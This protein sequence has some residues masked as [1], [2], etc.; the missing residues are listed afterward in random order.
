MA[1]ILIGRFRAY[2]TIKSVA[3]PTD[4]G[5]NSATFRPIPAP[6]NPA[7]VV[8]PQFFIAARPGP[9]TV[10]FHLSTNSNAGLRPRRHA[11]PQDTISCEF[12]SLE[13]G[14]VMLLRFRSLP[15]FRGASG[16]VFLCR[17]NTFF[18]WPIG[19]V[20]NFH[21]SLCDAILNI[22]IRYA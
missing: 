14:K 17:G 10:A 15:P 12:S 2:Y 16:F 5:L 22:I 1:C 7:T 19:N 3:A 21:K 6:H 4:S 18:I 8:C 9:S 13:I 11:S 20:V